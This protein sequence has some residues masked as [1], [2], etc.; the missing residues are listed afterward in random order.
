MSDINDVLAALRTAALSDPELLSA[1]WDTRSDQDPL[2]A[3]C[4]CAGE[5]GYALSLGD[6]LAVGEEYSCNQCKSTNG[7]NPSPYI[8]FDDAYENFFSSLGPSPSGPK[9]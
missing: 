5:A 3:F 8:Y 7:G 1:L 6:L 2:A 4:R 9:C